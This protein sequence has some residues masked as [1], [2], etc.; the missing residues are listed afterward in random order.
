VTFLQP[1]WLLLAAA[2]VVPIVIH[3]LRRRIGRR[4]ELPTA[5]YL[6]R[7][8]AEHSRELRARNLLLMILRAAAIVFLAIALARPLVPFGSG[9]PAPAALAVAV[10]NSLS[11]GAVIQGT[12]TLEWLVQGAVRA[13]AGA[14]PQDRLWLVTADAQIVSGSPHELSERLARL[15]PMPGRGDML[16]AIALA[17]AAVEGSGLPGE[18]ALL[19]DGQATQWD[20]TVPLNGAQITILLPADPPPPNRAVIEATPEPLRWSS[21]RGSVRIA[22]LSAD[23]VLYRVAHGGRQQIRGVAEPDARLRVPVTVAAA[24]W[25]AGTVETERDELPADDVRHFAAFAGPLARVAAHASAGEFAAT[26]VATLVDGGRLASGSEVTLASADAASR[27]PAL[28]T[29]PLD[30]VRIGAANRALERLGVPWRFAAAVT[31][32]VTAAADSALFGGAPPPAVVL[33]YRLQSVAGDTGEQVD[34]LA[35]AA[36]EPWIV[37]G[38]RYMLVASALDPASTSLPVGAGFLPWIE[39]MV[40]HRL[41]GDARGII[42]AEPGDGIVLP[43]WADAVEG[44]TQSATPGVRRLSFALPGVYYLLGNGARAGAVVVN[45]PRSESVLERLSTDQLRGRF[46]GARRVSVSTDPERFARSLH[47]AR[48]RTEA[49][50]AA[51]LLVAVLLLL[52]MLLRSNRWSRKAVG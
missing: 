50:G 29:A 38:S 10:D 41:A 30:P 14:R 45:P 52:E 48:G 46:P 2:A 39:R 3:L 26:A 11:S 22:I 35:T 16:R 21:G 1:W 37:A 8:E 25:V 15:R 28:L 49:T 4:V 27:L 17:Q 51:L 44:A 23:S 12:A 47:G 24:G 34:T 9:S 40:S 13:I 7:A 33:R 19:T 31:D 20:A 32:S 6:A 43:A 18:I 5:R 42:E 36:G